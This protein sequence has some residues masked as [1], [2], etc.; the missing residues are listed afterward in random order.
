MLAAVSGGGQATPDS[1]SA[2][3]ITTKLTKFFKPRANHPV[4]VILPLSSSSTKLL[5]MTDCSSTVMS[6]SD[7][8]DD[9]TALSSDIDSG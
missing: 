6:L 9:V 3:T 1:L 4:P 5:S 2:I 8:G 7:F